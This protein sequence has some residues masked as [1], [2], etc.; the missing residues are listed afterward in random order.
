MSSVGLLY[1][2][3]VLFINS[4]MLLGKIDGKSFERIV[5]LVQDLGSGLNVK[6]E[7]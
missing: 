6:S 5:K 4:F 2:G 7:Y 3:A 1:V